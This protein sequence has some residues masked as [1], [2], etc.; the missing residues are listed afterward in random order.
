LIGEEAVEWIDKLQVPGLMLAGIVIYFLFKQNGQLIGLLSEQ[1]A[2]LAEVTSMLRQIC[3][4][5][6]IGGQE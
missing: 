4:R 5:A 1:R 2:T 6:K 3:T